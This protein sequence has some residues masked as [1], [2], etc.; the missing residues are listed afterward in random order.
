VSFLLNSLP[1]VALKMGCQQGAARAHP[2]EWGCNRTATPPPAN[3]QRN[4]PG[5]VALSILRRYCFAE[6]TADIGAALVP[7]RIA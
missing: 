4:P 5:W 2:P 7:W 6:I 1:F 3:F